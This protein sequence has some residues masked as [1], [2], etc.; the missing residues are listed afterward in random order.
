MWKM[1]RFSREIVQEYS[2]IKFYFYYFLYL[3]LHDSH[4][5]LV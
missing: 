3:L 2:D 5:L 4:F 1:V